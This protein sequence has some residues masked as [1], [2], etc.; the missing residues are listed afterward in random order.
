[1]DELRPFG[2][3]SCKSQMGEEFGVVEPGFIGNF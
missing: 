3:F 2:N 1:M